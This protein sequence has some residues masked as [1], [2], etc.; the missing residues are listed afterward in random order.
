MQRMLETLQDWETQ[1]LEE[2][3]YQKEYYLEMVAEFEKLSLYDK[4]PDVYWDSNEDEG[5][6]QLDWRR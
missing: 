5:F 3:Q 4:V 6:S 2:L 1:E